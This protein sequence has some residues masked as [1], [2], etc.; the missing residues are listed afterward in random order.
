MQSLIK[1]KF[2]DDSRSSRWLCEEYYDIVNSMVQ[3][4]LNNS[5]DFEADQIM[6]MIIHKLIDEDDVESVMEVQKV[7]ML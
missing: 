7:K 5:S 6:G 1:S 2:L 4:D 3:V